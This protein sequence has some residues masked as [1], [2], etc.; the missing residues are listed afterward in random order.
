MR[1]QKKEEPVS[2]QTT[3]L[4]DVL[5][6]LLVFFIMVSQVKTSNVRVKLPEVQGNQSSTPASKK[7]REITITLDQQSKLYLGS[8]VI[9]TE[10][11]K[12]QLAEIWRKEGKN[13]SV[14]IRTDDVAKS[15]RLVEVLH[16]V[17][18][19]GFEQIDIATKAK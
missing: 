11:L 3:S 13:T 15:G 14:T 18:E 6:I 7:N 10:Q 8:E 5:F 16:C 12:R 1:R 2:F 17:R 4:V 9:E 19:V